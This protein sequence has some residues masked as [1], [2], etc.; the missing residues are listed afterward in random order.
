MSYG[1]AGRRCSCERTRNKDI[2]GVWIV[3]AEPVQLLVEMNDSQA[4]FSAG[5]GGRL[6]RD[7]GREEGWGRRRTGRVDA[8]RWIRGTDAAPTTR[9]AG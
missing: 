8:G 1:D 3:A 4:G 5:H 6:M 9:T 7:K 2:R